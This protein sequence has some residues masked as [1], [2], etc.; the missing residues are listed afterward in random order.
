[1]VNVNT[2]PTVLVW[3]ILGL[4][5]IEGATTFLTATSAMP[6]PLVL[7]S[8]QQFVKVAGKLVTFGL[9][10]WPSGAVK[11]HVGHRWI[12]VATCGLE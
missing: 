1:M 11:W 7:V 5:G 8:L 9:A 10:V 3:L 6:V 4:P 12:G 2:N